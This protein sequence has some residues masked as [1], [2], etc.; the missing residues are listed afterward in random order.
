LFTVHVAPNR[1][2]SLKKKEVWLDYR[3]DLADS[4]KSKYKID[5]LSGSVLNL[6]SPGEY[7]H[8]NPSYILRDEEFITE[9]WVKRKLM[10]RDSKYYYKFKDN[11]GKLANLLIPLD[12]IPEPMMRCHC[13]FLGWTFQHDDV[14][15]NMKDHR[16]GDFESGFD[17]VSAANKVFCDILLDKYGREYEDNFPDV[18]FPHFKSLCHVWKDFHAQLHNVI[19]FYEARNGPFLKYMFEY[20]DSYV[21]SHGERIN[22]KF[23]EESGK[24]WLRFATGWKPWIELVCLVRGV[25][26]PTPLRRD[27][28]WIRLRMASED[29]IGFINDIFG[30]SKDLLYDETDTLVMFK[31]IEKKVQLEKA[32]KD[33]VEFL[34]EQIQDMVLLIEVLRKRHTNNPHAEGYLRAVEDFIDGYIIWCS[35]CHRYGGK[36]T[37]SYREAESSQVK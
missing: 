17:T 5:H 21:M 20:F 10:E 9:W 16:T 1:K 28:Y 4:V 7:I 26:I 3:I 34:N 6:L 29:V 35:T 11:F 22:R 13:L 18:N 23:S 12:H 33:T 24:F 37:L 32:Y 27:F 19:P 31:H 14:L 30:I 8:P 36:T 15:D 25:V 2:S